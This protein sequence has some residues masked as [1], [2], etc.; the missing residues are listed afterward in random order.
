MTSSPQNAV[1]EVNLLI[2]TEMQFAVERYEDGSSR[3]TRFIDLVNRYT[4][5]PNSPFQPVDEEEL[6]SDTSLFFI[7]RYLDMYRLTNSKR[8]DT[9]VHHRYACF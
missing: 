9:F 7:L 2:L 3:A 6:R 8:K 4:D 5:F 1:S